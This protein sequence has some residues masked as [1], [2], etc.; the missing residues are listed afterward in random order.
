MVLDPRFDRALWSSR[1]NALS[2]SMSE[3]SAMTTMK[4]VDAGVKAKAQ[5]HKA[6]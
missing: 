6:R 1:L 2:A 3:A 4:T 5:I